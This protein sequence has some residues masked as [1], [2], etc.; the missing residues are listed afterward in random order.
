MKPAWG[1][2][3][4][5]EDARYE[6]TPR[7]EPAR[8]E[9]VPHD[10]NERP[11]HFSFTPL[12]RLG[13]TND[14]SLFGKRTFLV[15]HGRRRTCQFSAIAWVVGSFALSGVRDLSPALVVAYAS[16]VGPERLHRPRGD[17]LPGVLLGPTGQVGESSVVGEDLDHR[18]DQAQALL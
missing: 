17:Q 1:P 9:Q 12:A 2:G 11:L 14:P 6:P 7:Y 18:L 10:T 8:Y 3:S 5:D 15:R 4:G 16:S 13:A